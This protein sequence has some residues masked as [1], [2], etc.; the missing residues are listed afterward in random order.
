MCQGTPG[1]RGETGE[2]GSVGPPVS[3]CSPLISTTIIPT[4][5][6]LFLT[7]GADGPTGDTGAA[8][9]RGETV[10]YDFQGNVHC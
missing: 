9:P 8:G 4:L 10:S 6:I 7:Q 2:V 1:A 3:R 5:L